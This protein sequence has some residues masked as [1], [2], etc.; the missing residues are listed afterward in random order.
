MLFTP[1]INL[2]IKNLSKFQHL[3]LILLLTLIYSITCNF[4]PFIGYDAVVWFINLYLIGSW[5]SKYYRKGS[6]KAVISFGIFTSVY[7][8]SIIINQKLGY[9]NNPLALENGPLTLIMSICI[10]IDFLYVPTFK[11]KFINMLGSI[12]FG[13]YLIQDHE[14]CRVFFW[15]SVLKVSAHAA[16]YHLWMWV[17]VYVPIAFIMCGIVDLIRKNT[18]EKIYLFI[19]DYIGKKIKP[20]YNSICNRIKQ[21]DISI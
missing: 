1:F 10:F 20:R 18:I 6:H 8:I 21:K 13:V 19:I 14:L 12:T 9:I 17:I 4:Y 7:L 16:S 11:S 2:L 3:S 5:I 15:N